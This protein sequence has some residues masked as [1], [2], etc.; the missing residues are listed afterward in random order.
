MLTAM[1][2]GAEARARQRALDSRRRRTIAQLSRRRVQ[3][4]GSTCTT[5]AGKNVRF[6]IRRL[7]A[8]AFTQ[9][10]CCCC[11]LLSSKQCRERWCDH[12]DPTIKRGEFSAEEDLVILDSQAALG[13]RWKE[14]CSL[15]PGA[16]PSLDS[17]SI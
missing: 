10:V 8:A 16:I 12:L 14:I 5:Y 1:E 11:I 7:V 15:L 6:V 13:N 3:L 17:T 2:K 9:L 4:M